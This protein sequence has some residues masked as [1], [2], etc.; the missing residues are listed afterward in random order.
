MPSYKNLTDVVRRILTEREETRSNWA[1]LFDAVLKCYDSQN[2]D[3]P[4]L[5]AIRKARQR[6]IQLFPE[7]AEEMQPGELHRRRTGK[8]QKVKAQCGGVSVL[9]L[10][11]GIMYDSIRHAAEQTGC[12]YT[13]IA[14]CAS[15]ESKSAGGM[16]W[17]YVLERETLCFSCQRACGRG[18]CPWATWFLPVTGWQ[19]DAV[20]RDYSGMKTRSY[21]VKSCPLYV[22]DQD[23]KEET[24]TN[25]DKER[26][27]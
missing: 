26:L 8:L 17:E 4:T 18:K 20:M 9:C 14:K 19:A 2:A 16:R 27:K 11:T 10:D 12:N 25:N 22:P 13:S 6:V 7:L 24:M 1:L 23:A 21:H 15:G 3:R 5:S